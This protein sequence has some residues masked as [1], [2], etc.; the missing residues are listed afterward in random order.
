MLIWWLSSRTSVM[1]LP[2]KTH[3]QKLKRSP[4]WQ[5][6]SVQCRRSESQELIPN[7]HPSRA[8][9]ENKFPCCTCCLH[10]A[11]WSMHLHP[12]ESL[13]SRQKLRKQRQNT[14]HLH[15]AVV[16]G[17]YLQKVKWMS[18]IRSLTEQP[19]KWLTFLAW[20]LFK[21]SL[22]WGSECARQ[23]R[24]TE[25]KTIQDTK[26]ADARKDTLCHYATMLDQEISRV[27][28]VRS[29]CAS[30]AIATRSATEPLQCRFIAPWTFW[31]C[32]SSIASKSGTP[33][34]AFPS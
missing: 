30:A 5:S 28:N 18:E 12:I 27:K 22:A 17:A 20:L 13:F 3:Q 23:F 19:K 10:N 1:K 31:C 21:N 34:G 33:S 2:C 8:S 26:I 9:W 11:L 7:Q 14:L 15:D 16:H 29:A 6:S 4:Q 32:Y 24:I 25:Y